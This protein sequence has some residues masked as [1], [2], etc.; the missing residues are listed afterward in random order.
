[1]SMTAH[2]A[3]D[4]RGGTLEAG[5]FRELIQRRARPL[6]SLARY[7]Q[8]HATSRE[9]FSRPLLGRL[10]NESTQLEELLDAYGAANNRRWHPFRSAVSGIRRFTDIWYVLMH[11]R[12]ALPHYRLLE[13]E[14]DFHEATDRAEQFTME[15]L[16]RGASLLIDHAVSQQLD[17]PEPAREAEQYEEIL[18]TGRLPHDRA[19]RRIDNVSEAVTAM[20]TAFLNVAAESDILH[21]PMLEDPGDY[22]RFIPEPLCEER[23]RF[24]Q[25]RFH[26]LQSMYDTHVSETETELLDGDLPFLRG[27]ASVI[28]HLLETATS[29]VHHYQR[30][31]RAAAANPEEGETPLVSPEQLLE[32]LAEYSLA[33]CSRFLVAAKDLCQTMLRRYAKIGFVEVPAPRYRGFHVRPSTL[34]AKTVLHYGSEVRMEMDG[35]EFDAASPMDI[36]RANERI[37]ARKRHWLAEQLSELL[38]TENLEEISDPAERVRRVVWLLAEQG[39]LIVFQQPLE[40]REGDAAGQ[41]LFQQVTREI[42]RLQA[43]GKLD[44]DVKFTVGFRGDTRV[45]EDLSL[46]AENGYGEDHFGNNI[47]LPVRLAYLRR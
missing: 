38:E 23:L 3:T 20:A 30:H 43:T 36:F 42:A 35:E 41:G 21:L 12:H 19:P 22:D 1:M 2:T 11:I 17:I 32:V 5:V 15:C 33:F 7:V 14:E 18:P 37:N 9:D 34:V 40:L 24:L 8:D 10:L 46:L 26:N 45:L 27:H 16:L 28:F 44:M 31:V 39:K 47:P 4:L 29:L 25:D 13:I 6:L